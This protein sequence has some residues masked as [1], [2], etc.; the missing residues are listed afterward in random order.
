[1]D[2]VIGI[3]SGV[4]VAIGLGIFYARQ[5]K[6]AAVAGPQIMEALRE[7]SLTL[8]ELVVRLGMKD[9]FVSRGK[10]VTLLNPMVAR[11][12]LVQ[13]EPAGT[14]MKDRLSVMRFAL[15]GQ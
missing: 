7:G 8:P 2:N 15:P 10:V 9:G 3:A 6:K 11:G 1:M 5:N 12:E 14:T 4:G 13:T